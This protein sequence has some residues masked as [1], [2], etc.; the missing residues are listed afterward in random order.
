MGGSIAVRASRRPIFSGLALCD[1]NTPEQPPPLSHEFWAQ[2]GEPLWEFRSAIRQ[3]RE[4]VDRLG[5]QDPL[6]GLPA[7]VLGDLIQSPTL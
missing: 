2:Y 6:E 1:W 7:E 3:F 4:M 5:Y